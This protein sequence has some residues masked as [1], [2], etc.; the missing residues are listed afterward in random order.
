MATKGRSRRAVRLSIDQ[1][2]DIKERIA[3]RMTAVQ[4]R[5]APIEKTARAS[6]YGNEKVQDGDLTFD[7][8]AEHR[9][10]I[11]L[12]LLQRAGEICDLQRQVPYE[13]IPAQDKPSGGRERATLYLADFV[14]RDR[15]GATIV[16]D[17]KGYVTPEFRLKRKLM[18][19]RHG[20]EIKEIRS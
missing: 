2:T 5:D 12:T 7:S 19:W 11:H 3:G 4:M 13:L 14:Y 8:K 17:V 16:E 9:R 15:A 20:I 18:L 1:L 6:K 10:W